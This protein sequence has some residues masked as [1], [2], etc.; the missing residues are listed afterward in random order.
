MELGCR[1]R[2]LDTLFSFGKFSRHVF[3]EFENRN[4]PGQR[5]AWIWLVVA[6]NQLVSEVYW[7]LLPRIDMSCEVEV[8]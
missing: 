2:T 6:F 1:V 7:K 3:D 4:L 8:L 5:H